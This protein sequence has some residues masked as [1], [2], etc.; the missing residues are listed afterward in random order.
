[1][2]KHATTPRMVRTPLI[3]INFK[4]YDTVDD[5]K[6]IALARM[7][8]DVAKKQKV[9]IALAVD[10]LD[11]KA[12]AKAVTIP[13]FAQHVDAV[14]F[15]AH[16]GWIVPQSLKNAG[17]KGAILNHAEHPLTVKELEARVKKCKQVGLLTCVCANNLW[18]AVKVAALK[19]DFIAYEPPEL[20]G[21]NTSVSTA[22]PEVV[23]NFAHAMKKK[24]IR[25]LCGAGVKTAE[26]VSISLKLGM[27]G[28]LLASGIT[29]AKDPKAALLGLING[30]KKYA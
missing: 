26:D 4:T 21:G 29:M 14:D 24:K 10:A 16:T 1:M 28:V 30:I 6:A 20:I 15:G 7:C 9:S 2:A 17:V 11:V 25:P 23:K 27:H 19:P 8:Q 12:V 22:R 18:T 3:L 13:I 5:K